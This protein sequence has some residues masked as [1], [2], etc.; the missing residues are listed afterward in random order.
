MDKQEARKLL[1]GEFGE[2]LVKLAMNSVTPLFWGV[3][4]KSENSVLNSGSAFALDCGQG[5][6]IVTAAHV[7]ESYIEAKKKNS[8]LVCQLGRMS[9]ELESRLIDSLGSSTVDIATFRVSAEEISKW[10]SWG[11]NVLTYSEHSWPPRKA[12]TDEGALFGGFP[13]KLRLEPGSMQC[14]FGLYTALT[15]VS[16]SS[17]RHISCLFEREEWIDVIGNGIPEEGYDLGGI[18]GAPMLIL[19]WS[20]SGIFSWFLGGIIYTSSTS[21]GEIVCAYHSCHINSD[22]SLNAPA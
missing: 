4:E 22:G 12:L 13:G 19:E 20:E 1:T 2:E 16:S 17:E 14:N 11:K 7:Y 6:F 9:F 21:L 18:S 10:K 15:P 5:P 8:D 3:P